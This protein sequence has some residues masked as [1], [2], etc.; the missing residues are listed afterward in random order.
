VAVDDVLDAD[1]PDDPDDSD[2]PDD[3]VPDVLAAEAGVDGVDVAPSFFAPWL[4]LSA[5][6]EAVLAVERESVL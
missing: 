4:E 2:D 3:E 6:A 5:G 1:D